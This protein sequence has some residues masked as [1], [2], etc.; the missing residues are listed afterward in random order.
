MTRRE[1]IQYLYEEK[2]KEELENAPLKRLVLKD[3][4]IWCAEP[5]NTK[6]SDSFD[7][8]RYE[9]VYVPRS[10]SALL[11]CPL[12]RSPAREPWNHRR[13]GFRHTTVTHVIFLSYMKTDGESLGRMGYINQAFTDP[14]KRQDRVVELGVSK[15]RTEA[16][17]V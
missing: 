14:G 2:L 1:F 4:V 12:S 3:K 7:H 8:R 6:V 15:H 9:M 11:F 16:D 10:V 13:A 5:G 17:R